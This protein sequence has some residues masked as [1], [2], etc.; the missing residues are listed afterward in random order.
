[1]RKFYSIV[2]LSCIIAMGVQ[3]TSAQLE[4]VA[5]YKL[6]EPD[7]TNVEDATGNGNDGEV[8]C[9]TCWV[10]EG[11]V[12]GALAFNGIARVTLPGQDIGLDS[13]RGSVAFWLKS[14]DPSSI[15]TMFWAGDNTSGTGFGPENELHVHLEMAVDNV[16]TGGE[17]SFVIAGP[18]GQHT[19]CFS[20]PDKEGGLGAPPSDEAI[21][22]ADEEWH[23]IACTWSNNEQAILYIDG[24]EVHVV[25]YVNPDPA[26]DMTVM[27]IG[28]MAAGNR[29]FRGLIDELVLYN[30][31]LIL[32][33]IQH[34]F[35]LTSVEDFRASSD[36]VLGNY[37]NPFNESTTIRY[38][39]DREGDVTLSVYNQIGQKV[40]DL[41]A[42]SQGS[43][44][45]SVTWDGCNESG[46]KLPSGIYMYRLQ[47][48]DVVQTRRAMIMR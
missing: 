45:H 6:D 26:F 34:L 36:F 16:W 19:F 11:K 12:N 30:E 7:G 27:Y 1:M 37:P 48:D 9:D 24:E 40:R 10:Q 20:D 21:L 8:D 42:E 29:G 13:E 17:A 4:L 15:Y 46:E 35:N 33:D 23:H 5:Y 2:F 3:M 18:S 43:G 41:I 32:E 44:S 28:T 47:V 39:L 25:D 22:L 31:V 38:R 14:S